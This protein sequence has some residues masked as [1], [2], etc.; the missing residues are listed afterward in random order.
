MKRRA[1]QVTVGMSRA[2]VEEIF[3][4]PLLTLNRAAPATGKLLCWTDWF[5]QVDVTVDGKGS[6]E[7]VGVV[8][9][10]SP[11]RRTQKRIDAM[12]K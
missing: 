4:P 6:V 2:Q 10:N 11:I 1:Q 3:G 8:P 12:L 9:A 7:R 5:W